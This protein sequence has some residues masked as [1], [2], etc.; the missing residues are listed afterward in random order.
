MC[1]VCVCGVCVCRVCVCVCVSA[2]VCGVC[3][4][5]VSVCVRVCVCG[6]R[7][8]LDSDTDQSKGSMSYVI[9]FHQC[10]SSGGTS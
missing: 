10:R 8:I 3:G 6:N 2:R 1:L 5:S 4:V 9:R 7:H